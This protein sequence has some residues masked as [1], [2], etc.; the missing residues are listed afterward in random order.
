MRILFILDPLDS[1]KTYKDT[2]VAIMREAS[3]RGHDI[4]V[5]HVLHIRPR[6]LAISIELSRK[7]YVY[8]YIRDNALR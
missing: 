4:F 1:L 6:V 3:A 8:F 7:Q 5:C 2:S